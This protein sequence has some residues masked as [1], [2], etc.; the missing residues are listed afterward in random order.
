MGKPRVLDQSCP[1]NLRPTN[2]GAV[3]NRANPTNS[4]PQNAEP[5]LD[6]ATVD[7]STP[8]PNSAS[9]DLRAIAVAVDRVDIGEI[10]SR[11]W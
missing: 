4:R 10:R 8:P 7:S 2:A 11:I 6:L 9:R 1:A 3:R 5:V